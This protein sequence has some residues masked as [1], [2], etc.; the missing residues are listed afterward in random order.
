MRKGPVERRVYGDRFQTI[1]LLT[2]L[3]YEIFWYGRDMAD[4]AAIAGAARA[5][6]AET[7]RREYIVKLQYVLLAPRIWSAQGE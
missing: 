1:F 3:R 2:G 6:D 5:H 7:I 4:I